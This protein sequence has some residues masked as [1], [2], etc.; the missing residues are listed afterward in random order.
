[1][2]FLVIFLLYLVIFLPSLC[3]NLLRVA[4]MLSDYVGIYHKT[5]L[6]LSSIG[7][8]TKNILFTFFVCYCDVTTLKIVKKAMKLQKENPAGCAG[9]GK[10]SKGKKE[11]RK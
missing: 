3:T 5:Q 1:M 7:N 2:I 11:K 8:I 4:T 6:V 10:N 9:E